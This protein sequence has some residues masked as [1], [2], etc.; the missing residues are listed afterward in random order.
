MIIHLASHSSHSLTKHVHIC[1]DI[2]NKTKQETESSPEIFLLLLCL[3][4][5]YNQIC[6]CNYLLQEAV[7]LLHDSPWCQLLND[8][9]PLL[10]FLVTSFTCEAFIKLHNILNPQDMFF[11][12]GEKG[13]NGHCTLH[14]L[15]FYFFS[16]TAR[17][18]TSISA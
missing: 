8:G 14:S 15:F 10:F 17:L 4:E 2:C 6:K 18:I 13:V 7:L 16:W 12:R 1:H 5:Y 9:E 3:I 11:L